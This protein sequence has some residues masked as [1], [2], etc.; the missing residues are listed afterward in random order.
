MAVRCD[1][2][3]MQKAQIQTGRLSW[4]DGSRAGLVWE[5]VPKPYLHEVRAPEPGRR[6]VWGVGLPWPMNDVVAR[7]KNLEAMIPNLREQWERW[8]KGS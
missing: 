2:I 8:R 7:R 1:W 4:P 6:G 5:V 3:R